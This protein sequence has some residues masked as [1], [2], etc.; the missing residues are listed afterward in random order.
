[1]SYASVKKLCAE[2]NIPILAANKSMLIARLSKAR[3]QSPH[4]EEQP[5]SS[6][7]LALPLSREALTS[8]RL[9]YHWKN[10]YFSAL[11]LTILSMVVECFQYL[12]ATDH[13]LIITT[14]WNHFR[15]FRARNGK[16]LEERLYR[17]VQLTV[18]VTKEGKRLVMYVATFSQPIA[19]EEVRAQS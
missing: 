7:D 2:M 16:A 18:G 8:L 11:P 15:N 13:E 14:A 19:I 1:M 10:S 4:G 6:V 3:P 17:L 12:P 9:L 5:D